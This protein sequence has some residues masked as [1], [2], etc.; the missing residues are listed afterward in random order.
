MNVS[1][2]C[3]VLWTGIFFESTIARLLS[4]CGVNA[5]RSQE[6]LLP[7]MSLN[8]KIR[9]AFREDSRRPISDL[10]DRPSVWWLVLLLNMN[11]YNCLIPELEL[12]KSGNSFRQRHQTQFS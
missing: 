9:R 6:Y 11:R 4:F 8:G 1:I 3:N 10:R 7:A 12:F 5:E 2:G